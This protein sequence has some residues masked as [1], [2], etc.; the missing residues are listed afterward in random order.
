[1]ANWATTTYN[2]TGKKEDVKELYELIKS[3]E[4][5]ERKPMSEGADPSWEGN[6]ALALGED[7]E[8]KYLRGFFEYVEFDGEVL[9][10]D[11]NE[12]WQVTDLD[13]ILRSHYEGMRILYQSE[14]WGD[15]YFVTND[16]DQAVFSTRFAVYSVVDGDH[17]EEYCDTE[18]EALQ[19][20]AGRLER[21][22]ITKEELEKWNDEHE[23]DNEDEETNIVRIIAYRIID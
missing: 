21:D 19:Y 18:E 3:L 11:A 7:I 14:E 13:E 2:I 16:K 6:I 20:V 10:I 8:G 17:E 12:A 9:T 1:M 22:S 23:D 5:G 4:S 15:E